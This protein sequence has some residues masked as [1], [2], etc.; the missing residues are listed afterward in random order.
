M[1]P[2]SVGVVVD[3]V[4]R[5]IAVT[6]LIADMLLLP[7]PVLLRNSSNGAGKDK[8]RWRLLCLYAYCRAPFLQNCLIE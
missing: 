3:G 8:L 2:V 7:A 6:A 4:L 5:L 1:T